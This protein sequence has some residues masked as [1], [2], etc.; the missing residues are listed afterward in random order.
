M[1][2]SGIATPSGL[3]QRRQL[4]PDARVVQAGADRVRLD[5]LPGSVLGQHRE[6][7]VQDAGRT[8]SQRGRVVAEG[9]AATAGLHA[10]E[11]G[12]RPPSLNATF[13]WSRKRLTIG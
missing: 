6:R 4:R 13:P 2:F 1:M 10:D 8:E 12:G 7:A 3:S 11:P 5:D 9:V